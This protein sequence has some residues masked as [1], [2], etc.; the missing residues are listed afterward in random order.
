[1]NWARK[2]K[3]S[4]SGEWN[5]DDMPVI[6]ALEKGEIYTYPPPMVHGAMWYK[7]EKCCKKW[8]MW[9]EKGLE[10]RIQDAIDPEKHKPVPFTI[11]C[12]CGGMARHVDWQDDISLGGYKPIAEHMS[13]FK[14]DPSKD[15]GV[16]IVR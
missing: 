15:C 16:P 8:R 14:N 9:L 7:C 13:Y 6:K 11:M 5:M 12:K 2:A 3:K 10:D 4:V 1:M